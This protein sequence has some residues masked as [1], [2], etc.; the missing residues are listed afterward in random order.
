MNKNLLLT[1]ICL[2]F[3]FLNTTISQERI[4]G[5]IIDAQGE[6]LIGANV[7][8]RH[9][10]KIVSG[11]SAGIKGE[12]E[13]KM[14]A[15][16]TIEITYLGFKPQKL[17]LEDMQ[18][19]NLIVLEEENYGL[20]EVVVT[21]YQKMHYK[22]RLIGFVSHQKESKQESINKEIETETDKIN[23]NYYPNPTSGTVNIEVNMEL[24]GSIEI[25]DTKGSH[26]RS[27]PIVEYPI[28]ID[29]SSLVDGIYHLVYLNQEGVGEN[30]GEVVKIR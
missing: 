30:I 9:G 22:C 15:G 3:I 2:S 27:F 10:E 20:K 16:D 28:S 18:F 11:A 14:S 12:F 1:I 25:F 17:S 19:D 29:L 8:N 21:A 23:Y 24:T 5:T 4:K 26:I 7:I 13:I 6:F